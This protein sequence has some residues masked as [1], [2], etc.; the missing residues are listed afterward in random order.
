ML[1]KL[2]VTDFNPHLN[3]TFRVHLDALGVEPIE[4]ELVHVAEAGPGSRPAGT[5]GRTR[6]R[7][8][9]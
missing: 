5:T 3:D 1:D 8:R 6:G 9:R 2:Q 7:R 4:L